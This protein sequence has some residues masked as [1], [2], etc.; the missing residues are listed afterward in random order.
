MHRN[1]VTALRRFV[2]NGDKG[3][4]I[5]PVGLHPYVLLSF[6]YGGSRWRARKSGMFARIAA[7]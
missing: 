4:A 7:A 5:D 2:E 1:M 6:V 3:S